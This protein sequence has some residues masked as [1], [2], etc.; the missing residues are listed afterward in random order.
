MCNMFVYHKKENPKTKILGQS[1]GHSLKNRDC[2]HAKP[3]G[4]TKQER[5]GGVEYPQ[6]T[7]LY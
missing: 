5:W 7:L 3:R 2:P 6:R 1:E 4:G